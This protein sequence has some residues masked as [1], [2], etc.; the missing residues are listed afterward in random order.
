MKLYLACSTMALLCACTTTLDVEPYD[1]KTSARTDIVYALPMRQYEITVTRQIESCIGK[2]SGEQ[3]SIATS[4]D[5]KPGLVEDPDFTFA[6][7]PTSLSNWVNTASF[8]VE[9]HPGTRFLK[10]VNASAKDEAGPA[11]ASLIK[12]AAGLIGIATGTAASAEEGPPKLNGCT[13]SAKSALNDY[14]S[15]KDYLEDATDDLEDITRE[16]A[17]R[18]LAFGNLTRASDLDDNIKVLNAIAENI[19]TQEK[20]VEEAQKEFEAAKKAITNSHTFVWPRSTSRSRPEIVSGLPLRVIG[21]W[22]VT[23]DAEPAELFAPQ[24]YVSAEIARAR[25][26]TKGDMF[27]TDDGRQGQIYFRRSQPGVLVLKEVDHEGADFRH[28]RDCFND[29][30]PADDADTPPADRRGCQF[31]GG[32]RPPP[33]PSKA[34][35]T[36]K[37]SFPQLGLVQGLVVESRT[38]QSLSVSLGLDEKGDP[39][40]AGYTE[41][42]TPAVAAGSLFETAV[43]QAAAYEA[44]REGLA[45]SELD[46]ELKR[47]DSLVKIEKAH[48]E[49]NPEAPTELVALQAEIALLK[50]RAERAALGSGG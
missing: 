27:E 39:L 2:D 16:L 23:S 20:G 18:S 38:F 28:W 48:A 4:V 3:I 45:Q 36:E 22:V 10:T 41:T 37:D 35:K 9:F 6:V 43:S 7:D 42:G 50:A 24:F 13:T 25:T 46:A 15:K 1:P 44:A 32:N 5:L 49:L 19:S 17:L 11:L 29:D 33:F 14:Q 26:P 47:L 12:G 21:E 31:E 8:K 30:F 34:F 40:S